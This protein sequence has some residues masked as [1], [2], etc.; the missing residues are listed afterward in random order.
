MHR[1]RAY[2][3]L[4][5]STPEQLEGDSLR[6]QTTLAEDYAQRHGL[7]LDMKLSYR[8]LGMS[9]FRGSNANVG[10][11][12][13]FLEA[14]RVKQVPEGS[15]FLVESLDRISR[16]H[17]FDA[18]ALLSDMIRDGITVV[19]L[20]DER[21]YSLD[22]LRKDPMG[23]MY[24]IMGFMR[25][26]EESAVKSRRL[27]QAWENKR[28]NIASRP[29]TRRAPAWLT[30]DDGAKCFAPVPERAA[31]VRRIFDMTLAGAGQH[32]IAETFNLED[33][34][35]WGRST[36]WHRSYILKVLDSPAVIGT[37][38]PHE[39]EHVK[40]KKLR[41][42]SEPVLD[43]FPAVISEETWSAV[44]ALR[45]GAGKSPRG[46][47]AAAPITNILAYLAACP[48]CGKTMTRV[49][50]GRKSVSALVCTV[51]KSKA[52]GGQG[53]EYRSVRYQPLE[54]WLIDALPSA[55]K[56][57][58]GIEHAEDLNDE[59]WN[60]EQGIP[61]LEDEIQALLDNLGQERSAALRSRLQER[62]ARLDAAKLHLR[63]LIDRRDA[64][65]GR[66]VGSRI[67]RAV[68]ALTPAASGEVDRSEINL[69]LRGLFKR[70][71]INWPENT[72]DFEW[73]FGGVCS[74]RGNVPM[75]AYTSL[76]DTQK[77][78]SGT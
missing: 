14:V 26:N 15:F 19:T 20:L 24:S 36:H 23:M 38:T 60:F 7:E 37:F 58:E 18:Q 39:M 13:E 22:G 25:A 65:S 50:K 2:S 46:R 71:V 41:R 61:D 43:Y 63:N 56:T 64:A 42:P 6:R 44:K 32:K 53:C 66:V 68:S 16:D 29:L 34:P 1:P 52:K 78:S 10:K 67:M 35:T 73:H 49:Q 59:I 4:R 30:F 17:A 11:L 31:L 69:A 70:A 55:L 51:A 75:S 28:A 3:Y 54:K 74:V 76:E 5:F 45:G 33:L 8:D 57:Q 77:V 12:G 72:V 47:Q 27:K 40:G 9:A 21:V 48:R 62:E